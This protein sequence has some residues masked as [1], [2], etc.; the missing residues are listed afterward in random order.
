MGE[1]RGHALPV[2]MDY[3]R[4]HASCEIAMKQFQ[5]QEMVHAYLL[6]GAR[7]LG[8]ATFAK[9]L[10][11]T[12][13]CTSQNRPCGECEGCRHVLFGTN[14]DVLSVVPEGSKQ[15]GVEQVRKVLETISRHAFG[16]EYRVV[17]VEPV[18]RLTP[19]AQNALLKSLE[20]PPARVI[21]L[22]LAHEMTALL[23]TIASRCARIKLTPWPDDAV[24]GT[25]VKMGYGAENVRWVLPMCSGN[26]GDALFMLKEEA[27]QETIQQWLTCVLGMT[28]DADV[29]RLS[30]AMKD[31]RE[32]AQEN[33]NA[34]EMA[35]HQVLL[36]K[37][38]Q[39][40]VDSLRRYPQ[41]WQ[42][43]VQSAP[44][45]DVVNLLR[46]VMRARRL[47]SSQVNWQST[48]DQLLM[49]LLEERIKWRQ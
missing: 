8:K 5:K 1:A 26:I 11:C 49:K 23:G 42:D 31:A 15:I 14:P 27:R 6:S 44:L 18:E 38:G 24:E 20:E 16:A 25:L 12:L 30:T 21:F 35:L 46:E 7:G 3:H 37:T 4:L 40:G 36:V 10:V 39:M 19:Q 47:K 13:F 41:N 34:L 2:W 28:A 29:V 22:L 32:D 43:D 48:I 17:V 45:E 9:V 33:L